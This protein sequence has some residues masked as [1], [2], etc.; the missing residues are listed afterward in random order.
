[1]WLSKQ[2]YSL[3]PSLAPHRRAEPKQWVLEERTDLQERWE[4]PERPAKLFFNGI[5]MK[6][7][8]AT[9]HTPHPEREWRRRRWGGKVLNQILISEGQTCKKKGDPCV[10]SL[11]S[12][13]QPWNE[14]LW[15]VAPRNPKAH[16]SA[17]KSIAPLFLSLVF[18]CINL[19]SI[20]AVQFLSAL[21]GGVIESSVLGSRRHR[22]LGKYLRGVFGGKHLICSKYSAS[23]LHDPF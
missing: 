12:N 19:L 8:H 7:W 17:T 9:E 13:F 21:A 1:M 15:V 4:A 11:A 6:S 10:H 16:F 20:T 18:C 23:L 3:P 5:I 2:S 22:F 14:F